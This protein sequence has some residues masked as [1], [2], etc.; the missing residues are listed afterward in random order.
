MKKK[1]LVVLILV[2]SLC[3][4]AF[5]F[6]ETIVFKTGESVEGKLIEK[7]DKY[8][9]IDFHGV[10]LTYFYDEIENIEANEVDLR[11]IEEN[12][13][14]LSEIVRNA[15]EY[16]RKGQLDKVEE[17]YKE[18][19]ERFSNSA[20]LWA[21]RAGNSLD[22]GK[23]DE[24]I[25][26]CDQSLSFNPCCAEAYFVLGL[27]YAKKE[28]ED[29]AINYFQEA[30]K[31][32]PSFAPAYYDLGV[33]YV[34]KEKYSEGVDS[35]IKATQLDKKGIMEKKIKDAIGLSIQNAPTSIVIIKKVAEPK[36][37][38]LLPTIE[39]S[40]KKI[41]ESLLLEYK[42]KLQVH[43]VPDFIYYMNMGGISSQYRGEFEKSLK[44]TE[45]AL[46]MLKNNVDQSESEK[47]KF[48]NYLYRLLGDNH[49]TIFEFE[50]AEEN[51][52]EALKINPKDTNSLCGVAIVQTVRG[53]F[54]EARE[55]YRNVLVLNS[56]SV[57]AQEALRLLDINNK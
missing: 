14:A 30:I 43:G 22:Q 4:P 3:F 38:I 2:I 57:F 19:L 29:K 48:M 27:S 13:V 52:R 35:W 53:N 56:D 49:L 46:H 5:I 16:V 44:E 34:S 8:I 6:A 26:Y 7:T 24:A 45:L 51:Y 33:A 40:K 31:C 12:K 36:P 25:K 28:D 15:S 42:I 50:L 10:P 54:K 11:S 39:I 32:D 20:L 55:I 18:G 9:K 23:I 1:K 37:W 17:I 41:L 21:A 47:Q